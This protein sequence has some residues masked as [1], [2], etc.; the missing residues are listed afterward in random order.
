MNVKYGYS[1]DYMYEYVRFNQTIF[2]KRLAFKV[3][4]I[5]LTLSS[6]A[7]VLIVLQFRKPVKPGCKFFENGSR[8]SL[9]KWAEYWLS[10]P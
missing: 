9:Y 6:V 2:Q 7:G 1:F 5:F 3:I 4:G 8:Y 10:F